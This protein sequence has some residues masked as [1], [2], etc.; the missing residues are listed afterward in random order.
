MIKRL[1]REWF[2]R[3]RDELENRIKNILGI[4]RDKFI[5][6]HYRDPLSNVVIFDT[7]TKIY[8]KFPEYSCLEYDKN[9]NWYHITN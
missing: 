7:N 5:Y 1:R 3:K 2:L 6:Y 4:K 9:Y 8:Q